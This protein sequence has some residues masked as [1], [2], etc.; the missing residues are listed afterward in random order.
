MP[1][2]DLAQREGKRDCTEVC[3][4]DVFEVTRMTDADY[5]QLGLLGKLR[6]M[7]HKRQAACAVRAEDSHAC[8][9][10]VVACPEGAIT[11]RPGI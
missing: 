8:G 4:Y 1:V 11:L 6:S 5:A 3:S 7:A 2:V 9:L 10:C